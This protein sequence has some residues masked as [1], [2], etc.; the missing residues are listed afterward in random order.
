MSIPTLQDVLR[1]ADRKHS[2]LGHFNFS[3]IVVLKAVAGEAHQFSAPVLVGVSE[4]EREFLGIAQAAALV[5]SIRDEWE[6]PIYLNADHT[7]SLEKALEAAEAGFDMIVFDASRHAFDD[8]VLQTRQAVETVKSVNPN[9]VVEG[10]LGFI[11]PFRPTWVRLQLLRRP[12]NSWKQP[13]WTCLRPRW[14]PCTE[15]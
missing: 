3:D 1:E 14:A 12:D 11:P 5:R 6:M 2:A 10:E 13:R 7:H 9:I 4:S 15:C 8:H